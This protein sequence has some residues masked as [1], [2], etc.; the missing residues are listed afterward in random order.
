MN[1]EDPADKKGVESPIVQTE[2]HFPKFYSPT[3]HPIADEVNTRFVPRLNERTRDYETGRLDTTPDV[4]DETVFI[5][6]DES[7]EILV[8]EVK[9]RHNEDGFVKE[10]GEWV[11]CEKNENGEWEIC[12]EDGGVT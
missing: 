11:E 9:E 12:E 3:G 6:D 1:K 5:P 2:R 8:V 7:G 4:G 10:D